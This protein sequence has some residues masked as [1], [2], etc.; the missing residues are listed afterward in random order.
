MDEEF[1]KLEAN[2]SQFYDLVNK[3]IQ[4]IFECAYLRRL[5]QIQEKSREAHSLEKRRLFIK[6]KKFL[7]K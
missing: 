3:Q 7:M 1:K 4:D 2:N 5:V 6:L